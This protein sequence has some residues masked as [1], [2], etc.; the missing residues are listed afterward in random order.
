MRAK[1]L[2][3]VTLVAGLL[4]AGCGGEDNDSA[5]T[6][7]TYRAPVIEDPGPI[8]VHGLGINPA[9][10]ALFIA[11][12]TG[13]FRAPEGESTAKRVA[14]RYQDTMGFTVVGRDRFLGS[15]HPDQ[16]EKLPP[17]LGLIESEDAGRT[18][19]ALSLQGERD[20]HVL[21]ASGRTVYGYGSDF[22]SREQGLLVSD[23][24]GRSWEGRSAPEPLV[25]LVIEADDPETIT[26]SG[27][28]AVHRSE[29]GGRNWRPITNEGG[30]IA[31][32]PE[33]G[34]VLINAEGLVLTGGEDGTALTRVSQVGGAPAALEGI[35]DELYVAIHDG[36]VK[37]S[38]DGGRSWSVRSAPVTQLR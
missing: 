10:G 33:G 11:T 28:R 37:R 9:D 35:G 1:R 36:T 30:L 13:L 5:D 17:F 6:E 15:G 2:T 16:R 21:E 38:T 8:H 24:G 20:F 7:T 29:D 23:D 14:G 25:S 12:H 19:R 31:S 22:E 18:W 26:A 3:S 4:A 32:S 34:L 27:A